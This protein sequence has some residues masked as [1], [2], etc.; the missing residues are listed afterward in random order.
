MA[1][2][3]KEIGAGVEWIAVA[4]YNT[5]HPHAHIAMRGIDRRDREI[6]LPKEFV[7]Q[8]IRQISA[9]WCTQKLGYRTREQALDTQ[10]RE[11]SET[12]YTSM[13]RIIVRANPGAA[14]GTHFPVTSYRPKTHAAFRYSYLRRPPRRS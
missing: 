7:K 9:D 11:V 10:R 3:E 8:G 4:H 14:E 1:G 2:V 6:R 5:G 12:R 13:D